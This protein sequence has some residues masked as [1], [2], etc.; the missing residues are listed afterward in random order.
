MASVFKQ[1]F[2]KALWPM[3]GRGFIASVVGFIVLIILKICHVDISLWWGFLVGPVFAILYFMFKSKELVFDGNSLAVKRF[4]RPTRWFELRDFDYSIGHRAH[5]LFGLEIYCSSDIRLIE[6]S[7][8]Q[9]YEADLRFFRRATLNQ[10]ET[11]IKRAE[12]IRGNGF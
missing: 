5:C 4:C 10:V 8:G 9:I 7:S 3:T 11:A 12:T 1:N 2:W 6:K